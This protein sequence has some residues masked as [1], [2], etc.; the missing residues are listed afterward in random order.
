MP[1]FLSKSNPKKNNFCNFERANIEITTILSDSLAP[2]KILTATTSRGVP[3]GG[4]SNLKW[5]ST[6]IIHNH[7]QT[8]NPNFAADFVCWFCDV[9]LKN[10]ARVM[11]VKI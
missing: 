2:K 10:N 7:F 3:K 1:W 5:Q 11:Y 8:L 6:W 4:E 9:T